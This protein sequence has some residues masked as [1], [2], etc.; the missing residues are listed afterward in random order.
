MPEL[1]VA[2][3]FVIRRRRKSDRIR[4]IEDEILNEELGEVP[5]EVPNE[6][7][8]EAP[9]EAPVEAPDEIP[10]E[11]PDEVLNEVPFCPS[12]NLVTKLRDTPRYLFRVW[13][14]A[15]AG[16]NSNEWMISD[17][18]LNL[19]DI[20]ARGYPT[21][22]VALC[23]HLN[24]SRKKSCKDPFISW[25]TSLLVAILYAIFKH[26]HESVELNTIYLCIV[27][28]TLFPDGVFIKDLD[29]IEEVNN[30]T[31]IYHRELKNL[32]KLRDTP[33]KIY[34]GV[35]Y[36]GEYLSQGQT[37][38]KG[39]SYTMPFDKIINNHLF[40]IVP[41]FKAEIKSDAL[42]WAKAVLKFRE[43]FYN[44]MDPVEI[45]KAELSAAK[46]IALEFDT[47]WFLPMLA[48]LLSLRPHT[49]TDPAYKDLISELFSGACR[50]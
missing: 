25:T 31:P 22:A 1:H 11:A 13:S 45:D 42:Y 20:F 32:L 19:K 37:K 47:K 21:T 49:V 46:A 18:G 5:N 15:S 17:D 41:Q 14:K 12:G 3:P 7:P 38:I 28:T 34:P 9:V 40:A 30:K 44:E 50:S 24:W 27:D 33:S 26:K 16:E 10:V 4:F 8:D 6:V 29:L 2:T 36:Y 23:E 35:Y 48:N 43:P 39:R